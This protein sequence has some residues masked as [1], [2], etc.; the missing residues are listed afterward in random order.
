VTEYPFV[1]TD[2][3]DD[4]TYAQIKQAM[5]DIKSKEEIE[6]LLKPIKSTM[7][8][9]VPIADKDYDQL[10]NMIAVVR[11]DEKRLTEEGE[12]TK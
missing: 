4:E 6:M 8:G 9:L 10:K 2:R 11:E 5:I 12:K 1:A 3:L 7:T